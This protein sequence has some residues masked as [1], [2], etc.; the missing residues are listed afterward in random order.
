MPPRTAG[1]G[2]MLRVPLAC[3]E[4]LRRPD[5]HTVIPTVLAPTR[6]SWRLRSLAGLIACVALL[7]YALYVQF[8][9]NLQPCPLCILQRIAFM[10]LGVLFLVAALHAPGHGRGRLAYA[11]LEVVAALAGASVASRQLWLQ[12]QPPNPFGSCGAP[13][14]YMVKNLPLTEVIRKVFIGSG[15]CAVVNWRFLGMPMSF[16]TLVCFVVLAAWGAWAT[17]ARS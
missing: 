14:N 17:R 3:G 5:E 11:G 12:M 8:A 6:W 7:A 13:L 9:L 16:W 1:C 4:S 15:D 2:A 10:T